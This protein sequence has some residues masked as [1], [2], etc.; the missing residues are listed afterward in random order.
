[1]WARIENGKVAEV[2]DFNPSNKFHKSLIWKECS[3]EVQEGWIDSGQS[4]KKPPGPTM[5]DL[6]RQLRKKINKTTDELIAYGWVYNG[7]SVRL[8]ENDQRNHSNW[9][10][11]VSEML[12]E[13]TPENTL[14]PFSPK[15]WVDDEI[16]PV[17]LEINNFQEL[18]DF[19]RAGKLYIKKC[20]EDGWKIK[21]AVAD[22]TIDDLKNWT[23]KRPATT[24]ITR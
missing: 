8:Q 19:V 22:M 6:K 16:R 9:I 14:F 7:Q 13:G 12:D 10:T 21:A 20:L 4:F 1:M 5:V 17:Y 2:I 11:E 15:V 23:D 24:A 18:K 3:P